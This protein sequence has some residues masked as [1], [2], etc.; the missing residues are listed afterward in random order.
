MDDGSNTLAREKVAEGTLPS[1]ATVTCWA[2]PGGGENCG[3][4]GA[5]VPPS[6]IA[7]E[8]QSGALNVVLH[9]PCHATW[10]R[11]VEPA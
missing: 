8:L 2:G 9:A 7:F 5:V 11:V 6:E 10:L 1:S 4:C 3:L